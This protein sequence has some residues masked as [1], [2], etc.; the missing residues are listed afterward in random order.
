VCAHLCLPSSSLSLS[1]SGS[2][3]LCVSFS[4]QHKQSKKSNMS[5]LPRIPLLC[6]QHMLPVRGARTIKTVRNPLL[7]SY[8]THEP[9]SIKAWH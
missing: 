4:L 5:L 2:V 6:T 8:P 1:L 3:Y 7:F 9:H